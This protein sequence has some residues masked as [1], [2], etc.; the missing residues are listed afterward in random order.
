[1]DSNKGEK[2]KIE[3]ECKF[4]DYYTS[5]KTKFNRHCFTAKHKKVKD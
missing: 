2:I 3:Y 1:M 4:C 5:D